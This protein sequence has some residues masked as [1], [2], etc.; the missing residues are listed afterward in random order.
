[1]EEERTENTGSGE[2]ERKARHGREKDKT[3]GCVTKRGLEELRERELIK[4]WCLKG[5]SKGSVLC[6]IK[7]CLGIRRV[8]RI[9]WKERKGMKD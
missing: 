8:K 6:V 2:G 1:M 7:L 9:V 3:V 4:L 5:E